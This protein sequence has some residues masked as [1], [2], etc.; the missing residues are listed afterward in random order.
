MHKSK[1]G[2]PSQRIFVT[3]WVSTMAMGCRS[4]L[5]L[6]PFS[7]RTLECTSPRSLPTNTWSHKSEHLGQFRAEY[8]FVVRVWV[9]TRNLNGAHPDCGYVENRLL[10]PEP[11]CHGESVQ[12]SGQR[13]VYSRY[14][15]L[16]HKLTHDTGRTPV[17]SCIA[18]NPKLGSTVIEKGQPIRAC[19]NVF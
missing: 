13:C 2:F 6:N 10:V 5:G 4:A 12:A 16:L 15:G 17:P 7:A 18:S 8:G 19:G 9:R 3:G 14:L 11:D 1:P